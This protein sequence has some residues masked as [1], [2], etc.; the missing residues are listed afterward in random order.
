MEKLARLRERVSEAAAKIDSRVAE[1]VRSYRSQI[2]EKA[3]GEILPEI[4]VS[5]R[6][7]ENAVI[8]QVTPA[9]I[10]VKHEEGIARI[11]ANELPEELRTRFQFDESEMED[12]LERE[13]ARL[14]QME[15][16]I[17]AG[18][19][20]L[21][22]SERIKYLE[23]RSTLIDQ[24]LNRAKANLFTLRRQRRP[25]ARAIESANRQIKDAQ[26]EQT[27]VDRELTQLKR[28]VPKKEEAEQ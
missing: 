18:V 11:P 22:K 13:R 4:M 15:E 24:K 17:D 12:Y 26:A 5:G 20:D 14:G 23:R 19:V 3:A 8:S 1:Y 2:R 7:I 16:T 27:K 10:H 9:G 28:R 21:V 25:D 6:V